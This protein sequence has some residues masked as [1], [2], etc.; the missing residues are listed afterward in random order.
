MLEDSSLI[1]RSKNVSIAIAPSPALP[2][3]FGT[4]QDIY[5]LNTFGLLRRIAC[6]VFNINH[7]FALVYIKNL[8]PLVFKIN[9]CE[10]PAMV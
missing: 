10:A 4:A 8:T 3:P 7:R 1:L 2:L 6:V 9:Q 5:T